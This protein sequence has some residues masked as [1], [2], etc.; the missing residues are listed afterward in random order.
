MM[1]SFKGNGFTG[2]QKVENYLLYRCAE[3]TLNDGFDYFVL[4]SEDIES[5]HEYSSTRAHSA[6]P[7]LRRLS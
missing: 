1:V 4:A 6:P 7:P 2:R 3:V 5:K